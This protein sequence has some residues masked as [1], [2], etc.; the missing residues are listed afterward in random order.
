[1]NTKALLEEFEPEKRNSYGLPSIPHNSGN[2]YSPVDNSVNKSLPWM[3][4]IAVVSCSMAGFAIALSIGA[5]DVALRAE[6]TARD[7]DDNLDKKVLR[8][9]RLLQLEID[10]QGAALNRAGIS[11]HRET[12]K[13]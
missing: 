1:M 9:A 7:Q 4:L 6:K 10:E 11:L 5:R 13:P 2:V 8:E 3:V 12:D